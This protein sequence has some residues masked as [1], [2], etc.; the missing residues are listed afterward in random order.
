ME[1]W[2]QIKQNE[3]Y[4]ISNFGNI[5]RQK[6]DGSWYY[7][8]G[9]LQK[10]NGYKYANII[11]LSTKK[12]KMMY[13]HNLVLQAFKGDRPQRTA[14]SGRFVCDHTNR[15]KLDNR[16]DNLNW[17]TEL[18]N[19]RNTDSY[20]TEIATTDPKERKRQLRYWRIKNPDRV[21]KRSK[22]GCC[23]KIGENKYWCVIQIKGKRYKK[24]VHG[25]LEKAKKYCEF[26]KEY[27]S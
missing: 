25:D 21:K 1:F 3:K 10:T 24:T 19:L 5:K 9:S 22:C 11:D 16:I 17:V 8:K 15:N 6:M 12:R 4:S 26:M 2:R 23:K 7:L 20:N 27:Y 14:T 18:E 13:I